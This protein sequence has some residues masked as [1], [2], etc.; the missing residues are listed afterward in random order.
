MR[1]ISPV[2]RELYNHKQKQQS[3]VN[4]SAQQPEHIKQ[5]TESVD[6]IRK[7]IEDSLFAFKSTNSEQLKKDLAYDLYDEL[8]KRNVAI[9]FSIDNDLDQL[10]VKIVRKSTGKV[11]WEYPPSETI[12]LKKLARY[13]PGIF[14]ENKA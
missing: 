5:K 13:L 7:R 6:K 9:R 8:T 2:N 10:V 4:I 14:M 11:V 3:R 1:E 12:R